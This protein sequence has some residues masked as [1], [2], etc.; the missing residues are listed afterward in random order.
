MGGVSSPE[1]QEASSA[2]SCRAV[3]VT[4]RMG[5]CFRQVAESGFL[6]ELPNSLNYGERRISV[7]PELL[8]FIAGSSLQQN[9]AALWFK[10]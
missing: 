10:E 6:P 9:S 3:L 5:D 4:M 2:S 7:S 8:C 1:C